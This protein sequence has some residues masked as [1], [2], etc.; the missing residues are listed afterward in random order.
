MVRPLFINS[1]WGIA[2]NLITAVA[3]IAQVSMVTRGLGAAEYGKL[4][5][6]TLFPTMIQ[7]FAGFR[8][9]EFV[10][11]YCTLTLEQSRPEDAGNVALIG[12]AVDFIFSMAVLILVIISS[13]WYLNTTLGDNITLRLLIVYSAVSLFANALLP[14]S[15]AVLRVLGRFDWLS[16]QSVAASLT[17]LI[18]VLIVTVRGSDLTDMVTAFA[19]SNILTSIYSVALCLYGSRFRIKYVI[20]RSTFKYLRIH[21][22]EFFSF[23]GAGYIEGCV[24]AVSR[25]VDVI[26]LAHYW[27]PAEAGLYRA[28]NSVIH[29]FMNFLTPM[30]NAILPDLQR[31]VHK[32]HDGSVLSSLTVR[33]G[34]LTLVCLVVFSLG[35]GAIFIASPWLIT[36][37]MGQGYSQSIPIVRIMVWGTVAGAAFFWLPGFMLTISQQ[38]ARA[39]AVIISSTVQ[40]LLLF[41]F[42]PWYRSIGAAVSYVV[43]QIIFPVPMLV[44][45][46]ISKR[47]STMHD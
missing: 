6:I 27:G 41:I 13:N 39:V 3:G 31:S 43:L 22:L 28:A 12:W 33:L 25:N 20:S 38:W 37:I 36:A 34:G 5:V 15:Q 17:R 14:T 23:L 8:T 32:S 4:G 26:L 1:A 35:A 19:L 47:E 21:F 9:W 29:F 18:I 45:L 42:V 7:Q 11:R 46:L 30:V 10:A 44:W 24:Q 2:G 40:I 16:F